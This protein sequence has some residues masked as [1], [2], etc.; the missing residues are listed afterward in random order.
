MKGVKRRFRF[1]VGLIVWC[2]L[3]FSQQEVHPETVDELINVRAMLPGATEVIDVVQTGHFPLC[4]QFLIFLGGK[5]SLGISLKNDASASKEIIFMLGMA[6]SDA[7]N[8]PICRL[9]TSEG[10]ISQIVEV[11]SNASPYGFVWLYCGVAQADKDPVYFYELR[12]SFV[13]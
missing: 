12:L 10:M 8:S 11:G 1:V 2:L 6:L 9:G 13:P 3:V 7:G 5:G 4:P